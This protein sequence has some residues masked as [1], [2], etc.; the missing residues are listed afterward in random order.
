MSLVHMIRLQERFKAV[1]QLIIKFNCFQ[2]YSVT[3]ISPDTTD[4]L[5][6]FLEDHKEPPSSGNDSYTV[7]AED[8]K[9]LQQAVACLV[10]IIHLIHHA[11]LSN[12]HQVCKLYH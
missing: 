4:S 11:N 5:F 9:Q 8:Q 6:R 1:K 7:T 10:K 3:D 2:E 12:Q